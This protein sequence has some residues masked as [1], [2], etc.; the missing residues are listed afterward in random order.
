MNDQLI[1][2]NWKKY[3]DAYSRN[4]FY[5]FKLVSNGDKLEI[6]TDQRH[7][8]CTLGAEI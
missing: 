3:F 6:V 7:H 4:R 2:F 5:I 1:K 8:T